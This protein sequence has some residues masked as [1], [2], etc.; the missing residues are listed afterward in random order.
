MFF[1]IVVE[2][3]AKAYKEK[4]T[5]VFGGEG[6]PRFNLLLLGMGPDGHT[7]SLFP[8]HPLLN[9]IS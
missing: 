9:V 7:C 6:I 5:E 8:N 3:A 1:F 4:I 2:D